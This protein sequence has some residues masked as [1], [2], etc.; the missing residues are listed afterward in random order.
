[1]H[2]RQPPVHIGKEHT[3]SE[4]RAVEEAE[5]IVL[6]LT[7][8]LTNPGDGECL[9][10]YVVRMLDN[11]GCDNTLRWAGA[12]RDLRAPRATGLESRLGQMGGFCDCEIF[13]NGVTLAPRLLVGEDA[14][15]RWPN[16]RPRCDR[17]RA[18][19]TKG[20]ANWV[21]RRRW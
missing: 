9:Y 5:A 8:R 13:L 18:G 12:F 1:M 11:H 15:E 3:L 16:P 2:R 21:R 7:R 19:S 14:D 20:C 10:C 4:T 17:V 6:D